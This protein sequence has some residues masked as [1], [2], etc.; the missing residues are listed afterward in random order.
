MDQKN[1]L[2][3]LKRLDPSKLTDAQIASVKEHRLTTEDADTRALLESI[4]ALRY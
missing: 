3:R 1:D 4:E 2:E